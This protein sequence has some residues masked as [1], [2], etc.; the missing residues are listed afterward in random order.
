MGGREMPKLAV[1]AVSAVLALLPATTAANAAPGIRLKDPDALT[2]N[3]NIGGDLPDG[4]N[5]LVIPMPTILRV[6]PVIRDGSDKPVD[7][8]EGCSGQSTCLIS[9][10]CQDAPADAPVHMHTCMNL[11]HL[12]N[13]S[14]SRYDYYTEE[15]TGWMQGAN[16]HDLYRFKARFFANGHPYEPI[17]WAPT[18]DYSSGSCTTLNY[19]YSDKATFY[20]SYQLCDGKIHKYVDS[21]IFHVSWMAEGTGDRKVHDLQGNA[22]FAV[23]ENVVPTDMDRGVWGYYKD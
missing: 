11:Y 10:Y 17:T 21:D 22:T 16:Y 15:I 5:L 12:Q 1:I 7:D 9:H 20:Y 6:P 8:A 3:D 4:V 14:D 23:P 2:G 18:S 19:G 13:E